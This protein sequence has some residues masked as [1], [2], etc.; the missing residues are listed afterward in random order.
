MT[1]NQAKRKPLTK[2]Q[3]AEL[4]AAHKGRCFYCKKPILATEK[5]QDCHI[6]AREFFLGSEADDMSNR[7]PGHV[8][9]HKAD[10]REV[11]KAVA[12][13]NRIIKRIDG[14]RRPRK[15]IPGRGFDKTMR[16]KMDGTVVKLNADT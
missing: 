15:P 8:E 11:V 14:T 12:K 1:Y 4:F 10:T 2:K 7:A 16:K 5:W 13:S 6:I 9:C 3:R